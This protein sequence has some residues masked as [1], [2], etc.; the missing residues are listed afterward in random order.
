MDGKEPLSDLISHLLQQNRIVFGH[1][2]DPVHQPTGRL[3]H[4][5][6]PWILI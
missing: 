3:V 4:G 5:N 6:Q 1:L 2:R